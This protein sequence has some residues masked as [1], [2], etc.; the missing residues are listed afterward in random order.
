MRFPIPSF[1]ESLR[2]SLEL[3]IISSYSRLGK[4]R[5]DWILEEYLP[6]RGVFLEV[7]ALAGL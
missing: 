2:R 5:L 7:G 3:A 1:K 6:P 4:Y